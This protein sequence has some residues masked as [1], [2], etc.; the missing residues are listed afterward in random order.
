MSV[1]MYFCILCFPTMPCCV[2]TLFT[3][4]KV[5][6]AQGQNQVLLQVIIGV[7]TEGEIQILGRSVRVIFSWPY[8][9]KTSASGIHKPKKPC[10]KI[11][12]NKDKVKQYMRRNSC[13]W[14]QCIVFVR[15]KLTYNEW[16]MINYFRVGK[17]EKTKTGKKTC[18]L[19]V[20]YC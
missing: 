8:Y 13:S 3:L 18:Y 6:K 7:G 9:D 19:P 1:F 14:Q 2:L 16:H 15:S 20:G 5:I 10:R 11:K 17:K 4:I 12:R